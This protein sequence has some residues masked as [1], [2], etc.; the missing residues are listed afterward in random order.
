MPYLKMYRRGYLLAEHLYQMAIIR[1]EEKH[2]GQALQYMIES[3]L[4]SRQTRY[5]GFYAAYGKNGIE[6]S[7]ARSWT[8]ASGSST[9]PTR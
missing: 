4:I 3:F 1:W 6:A 2:H 8:G 9:T 5:V 7:T